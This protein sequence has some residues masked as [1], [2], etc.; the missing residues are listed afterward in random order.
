VCTNGRCAFECNI[1]TDCSQAGFCC[2]AHQCATG[3]ACDPEPVP[4]A[5]TSDGG[6]CAPCSANFQCDDGVW[7]NGQEICFAG[8]CAPAL[9]T[10]CNSHSACVLDVCSEVDHTCRSEAQ[11][12]EDVDLD[13]HLDYGCGGDDCDD[14]D[15]VI[16]SGATELCD[17]KDNDCDGLTDDRS[18][19]PFGP[20]YGNLPGY[21]HAA[22]APVEEGTLLFQ[23]KFGGAGFR[24]NAF[25]R[26]GVFT[27]FWASPNVAGT[28][29]EM[30]GQDVT[31][32]D[33]A[34]GGN[35]GVALYWTGVGS[36]WQRVSMWTIDPT[37][38]SGLPAPREI[39]SVMLGGKQSTAQYGQPD[40]VWTGT[41]F[42][43][44]WIGDGLTDHLGQVARL[45]VDGILS[46]ATIV[47]TSGGTGILG[48]R[49]KVAASGSTTAA[50][51]QAL[52]S[53]EVLLT[54]FD[55]NDGVLAGPVTLPAGAG[56]T[57]LAL[58]GTSNGY[59]ALWSDTANGAS[60]TFVSAAG[61][62][63]QT[64]KISGP[65]PFN[66]DGA[67]D[68]ENALFAL[69]YNGS[70]RFGFS[71]GSGPLELTVALT[72][73]PNASRSFNIAGYG[74]R[75]AVAYATTASALSDFRQVGCLPQP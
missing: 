9:D 14:L 50:L 28:Q 35:R 3:A 64:T 11:A 26:N 25:D 67:S 54:I 18:R 39:N 16:Y 36:K 42:F 2:V 51:Y 53:T 58:A 52:T 57:V 43:I 41:E 72:Q 59:L 19:V 38:D 33:A 69:D 73:P 68:G 1:D 10:P 55:S 40:M 61:V 65:L 21:V 75:F 17:G 70:V 22:A 45:S 49:I 5:G 74:G 47:P 37:G 71:A 23:G 4:D 15:D 13:G 24:V 31:L 56:A 30:Q 20:V 29:T 12:P 46:G 32:F 66:G 27:E 63:G 48:A 6:A 44:G 62:I 60:L 8:C 34:A 7:C